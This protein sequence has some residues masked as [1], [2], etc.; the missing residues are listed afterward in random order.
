L[1]LREY[2]LP[3]GY[4][5]SA[6]RSNVVESW[7]RR[8]DL[9]LTADDFERAD[10]LLVMDDGNLAAV[11]ARY[12]PAHR[13]K[14]RR[15]TEFCRAYDSRAVPDPYYGD[16]ADFERVLDLVEDAR[17]GL[18]AHVRRELAARDA[19]A[20]AGVAGQPGST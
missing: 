7:D 6:A 13:P 14:L 19:A 5:P 11:T 15:L 12:P 3:C 1:S 17:E 10:L 2:R 8:D 16:A 20:G 18:L 4:E 9:Q